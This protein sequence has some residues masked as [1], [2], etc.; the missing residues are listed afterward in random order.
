MRDSYNE[1]PLPPE[2]F[3][4]FE[5]YLGIVSL[6]DL[7]ARLLSE[8]FQLKESSR[9]PW[10]LFTYWNWMEAG[11]DIGWVYTNKRGSVKMPEPI[12]RIL[13][14]MEAEALAS[15]ANDE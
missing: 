8:G 6:D 1:Y 7:K 3:P 5:V 13:L 10:L 4:L 12:Y 15:G 11:T 9:N 14:K 2:G